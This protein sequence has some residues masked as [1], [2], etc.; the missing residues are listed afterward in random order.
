MNCRKLQ[1]EDIRRMWENACIEQEFR[2]SVGDFAQSIRYCKIA[3]R[4][5][6]TMM[7]FPLEN[8]LKT[9]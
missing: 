4:L 5:Y 1:Y 6:N 9:K 8:I 3:N 2:W 7:N